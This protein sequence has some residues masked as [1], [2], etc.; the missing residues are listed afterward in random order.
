MT[1]SYQVVCVIYAADE[2]AE[3]GVPGLLS[4]LVSLPGLKRGRLVKQ[5]RPRSGDYQDV[6]T[7]AETSLPW[8]RD[9]NQNVTKLHI[10]YPFPTLT[11]TFSAHFAL[12][13]FYLGLVGSNYL[14]WLWLSC[15]K[16]KAFTILLHNE[17]YKYKNK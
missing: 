13:H 8:R 3:D 15:S 14:I 2:E 7:L 9:G 10:I 17:E 6:P 16:F 11:F 4:Q 1:V 12:M 5:Y